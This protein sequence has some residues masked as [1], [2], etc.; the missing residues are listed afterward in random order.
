VVKPERRRAT[1]QDVLDAPEHKVAELVDGELFISPRPAAPHARVT[2]VLFGDLHHRFDDGGSSGGWVFLFEPELHFGGDVMVP[3][4]A[5]WRVERVPPMGDSYFT[6]APDW[7]CETL[8]PS[9]ERLDRAKKLPRY[10]AAGVGHVWLLNPIRR[11]LEVL[12]R[13]GAQW[14]LAATHDGDVVVRA[15]PFEAIEID[16]AR[17]WAR[18]PPPGRV[19]EELVFYQP[20]AP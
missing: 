5:G 15:E 11:T 4:I 8:S 3:D 17:L 1:Y 6:S 19:A 12:R 9:T 20:T 10:A 14:L 7:L 2:S 13:Q 18:L 16:L